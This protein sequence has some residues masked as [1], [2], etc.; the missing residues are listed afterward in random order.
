MAVKLKNHS[1]F[2][3]LDDKHRVPVGE[4][5]Y[6]VAAVDRG[7]KVIVGRNQTPT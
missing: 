3:C 2:V 7:K 4:P 6:P 1:I 5:G